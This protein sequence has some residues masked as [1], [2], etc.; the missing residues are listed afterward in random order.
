MW[1]LA[2]LFGS[3]EIGRFQQGPYHLQLQHRFARPL[4]PPRT[5]SA[6]SH[7]QRECSA[8]AFGRQAAGAA[9]RL[10]AARE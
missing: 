4:H 3:R 10:H 1:F 8:R 7:L 6:I 5:V 9:I 2:Q